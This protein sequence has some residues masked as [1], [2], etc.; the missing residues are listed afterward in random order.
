[1]SLLGRGLFAVVL[2]GVCQSVQADPQQA[3]LRLVLDVGERPAARL[4]LGF[5][6]RLPAPGAHRDAAFSLPLLSYRDGL[7]A[8]LLRAAGDSRT[9]CERSRTGCIAFAS[10]IGIGIFFVVTQ[11]EH[12]SENT[13]TVVVIN[14]GTTESRSWPALR[15]KGGGP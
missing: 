12:D 1:M 6:P 10:L 13:R 14:S 8:P 9:F 15:P 11:Y 3:M 4:T 2:G 5:R 7:H